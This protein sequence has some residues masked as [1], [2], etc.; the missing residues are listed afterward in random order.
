MKTQ[1]LVAAVCCCTPCF[2][3]A[4]VP[5]QIIYSCLKTQST[6]DVHY[7]DLSP[8]NFSVEEDKDT[9]RNATTVVHRRHKYGIWEST[10][11][12]NFGLMFDSASIPVARVKQVGPIAPA[13]F[14]PY[15]ALW[16]EARY[17]KHLYL[18]ITFNFEGLGKSGSFQNVRGTYAVDLGKPTQFYFAAG[19]IRTIKN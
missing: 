13:P 17:R 7:V 6:R 11:S 2:A 14:V 3:S 12:D 10:D 9:K 8:T 1:L 18:C 19:D 4:A 15:T 5:E 16:G